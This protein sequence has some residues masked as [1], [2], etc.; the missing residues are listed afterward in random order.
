MTT[1]ETIL[2]N[3]PFI[4]SEVG[5]NWL[6]LQDCLDSITASKH[7]GADAVKFQMFDY[8]SLYGFI[9]KVE[10]EV[11]NFWY[12]T[13][14][15]TV[16]KKPLHG[17]IP[18]EW[19]E[20]LWEKCRA[21]GI[22]FMCTPFSLESAQLIN[23]YVNYH[24]VASSDLE[25]KEL[26]ELL[27]SFGKPVFFST[28]GHTE[29]HIQRVLSLLGSVPSV[30]L[31]C[32]SSYPARTTQLNLIPYLKDKFH[33]FVGFSDHSI[34]IFDHPRNAVNLGAIV[35]EKHFKLKDMPTPDNPHSLNPEEFALMVKNIRQQHA[36]KLLTHEEQDMV[37]MYNR[38]LIAIADINEGDILQLGLNYGAF[39]SFTPNKGGLSAW[40][41]S[42]IDGKTSRLKLKQGDHITIDTVLI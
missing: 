27:H 42:E 20:P 16:N 18:P 3:K 17:G 24:K 2:K 39:R 13:D 40:L 4:I 37:L 10:I 5:S 11:P 30:I 14:K 1:L 26:F 12:G 35:I 34:D 28:G 38:R 41:A 19:L 32:V 6:T 36:T 8:Q 15:H 33:N 21:Q 29:E 7:A 25:Y 31:Y 23:P 22:E 9:P